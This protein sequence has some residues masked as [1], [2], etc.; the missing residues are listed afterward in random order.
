MQPKIHLTAEEFS[1]VLPESNFCQYYIFTASTNNGVSA[2]FVSQKIV[3]FQPEVTHIQ[4]DGT[5]HAVPM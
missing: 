1:Q 5:F 2:V 3:N 4:F